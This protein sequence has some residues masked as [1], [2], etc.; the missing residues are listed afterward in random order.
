[1]SPVPLSPGCVPER[2][3]AAHAYCPR[4]ASM[5]GFGL[6]LVEAE[7]L[8]P[9]YPALVCEACGQEYDRDTIAQVLATWQALAALVS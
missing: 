7:G 9:A 4:C 2:W 8:A 1:M 3:N 6:I 5:R